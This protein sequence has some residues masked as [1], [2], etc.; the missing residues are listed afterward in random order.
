MSK[1]PTFVV[2]DYHAESRFLLVKTL[3]RKF[4]EAVVHETDEADKAIELARA[5]DLGA[6]IAHRTFEMEGEELVR[7]LREADPKVPIIMVSGIDRSA[8]AKAA[9]ATT[10]LHYD[11]WLMIGSVVEQHLRAPDGASA[12]DVCAVA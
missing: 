2:I 9:G 3:R 4:P 6:L 8:V 1:A 12:S 5:V 11:N 10:F 7:R